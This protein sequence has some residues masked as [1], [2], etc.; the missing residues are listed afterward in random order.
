M[1][2]TSIFILKYFLR[3]PV[4][5]SREFT[6]PLGQPLRA[7]DLGYTCAHA[8][9]H[10]Q[11]EGEG[12]YNIH[13]HTHKLTHTRV[14]LTHGLAYAHMYTPH[15]S[16]EHSH[17]CAHTFPP[18]TKLIYTSSYIFTYSRAQKYNHTY[19]YSFVPLCW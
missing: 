10:I 5:K 9:T 13:V 4:T 16:S 3:M 6:F 2:N 8:H 18:Y 14:V 11:R 19:F 1:T 7:Y 17:K 12:V 15:N